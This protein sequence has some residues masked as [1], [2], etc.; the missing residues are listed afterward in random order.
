MR[1]FSLSATEREMLEELKEILEAFEFVTDE[2]ESN[3]INISRVY[4][5][6]TFIAHFS[7]PLSVRFVLKHWV[8]C[9]VI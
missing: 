6:I 4:P 8:S 9:F 3:R 1:K 2:L 7:L 5:G